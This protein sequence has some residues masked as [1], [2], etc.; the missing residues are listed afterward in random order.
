MNNLN[1]NRDFAWLHHGVTLLVTHA[2]MSGLHPRPP[3]K[4]IWLYNLKSTIIDEH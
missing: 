4:Q 2:S 1:P 3:E